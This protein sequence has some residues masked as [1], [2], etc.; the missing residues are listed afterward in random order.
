MKIIEKLNAKKDIYNGNPVTLVFLGDSITQGCF[1][2]YMQTEDQL[3]TVF[4]YRN[5]Y[6]SRLREILN[7]LYPSVQIN[8]INSGISGG[9]APNGLSRLDRDVLNFNPDLCVVSFLL[10]DSTLG[11]E[12]IEQ[13]KNALND[14]FVKL[15]KHNVEIIMM[16]PCTMCYK[17][18]YHLKDQL[19]IKLSEQFAKLQNDGVIDAYIEAARDVCESESVKICDLASIWEKLEKSGVDTTE[20]LTNKLNHPFREYHYYIAIKLIETIFDL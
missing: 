4:E 11:V 7:I 3:T 1:E 13:Y 20:L 18:S 9:S 16:L 5:A 6:S 2:C 14:I 17:T 19:F 12:G 15:K 10:N 8:I